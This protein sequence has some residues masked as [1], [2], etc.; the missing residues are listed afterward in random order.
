MSV[1]AY[2][3][4]AVLCL[5]MCQHIWFLDA[6]VRAYDQERD[7]HVLSFLRLLITTETTLHAF[8]DLEACPLLR[9]VAVL[10]LSCRQANDRR[11]QI[12]RPWLLD[13]TVRA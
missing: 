8:V 7:F 12:C 6:P 2:D 11:S 4:E 10:V 13:T 5:D 9:K 1:R 3:Q